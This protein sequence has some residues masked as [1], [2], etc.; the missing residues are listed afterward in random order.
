MYGLLLPEA[1]ATPPKGSSRRSSSLDTAPPPESET[2]SA[3]TL[4]RADS[5]ETEGTEYTTSNDMPPDGIV[6]RRVKNLT[7]QRN[8]KGAL[9]EM[10]SDFTDPLSN[11]T[12]DVNTR[13]TDLKG[14]DDS[15]G[16]LYEMD[17]DSTSIDPLSNL[18]SDMNVQLVSI[19]PDHKS[20]SSGA[21][22]EGGVV[23]ESR[24]GRVVDLVR[25]FAKAEAMR[26][27]RGSSASTD[28]EGAKD[29]A[30]DE[31]S[32]RKRQVPRAFE[33]FERNEMVCIIIIKLV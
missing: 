32:G 1:N 14:Q 30:G 9:Y 28:G 4:S 17:S 13:V 6:K 10:D 15:G 31:A 26:G 33:E 19:S 3:S 16:T 11:L 7:G 22:G 20:S 27:H 25:Q 5:E 23:I 24:T 29:G 21:E 8:R 2:T 12:S 18:I